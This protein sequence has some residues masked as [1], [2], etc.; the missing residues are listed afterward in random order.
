MLETVTSLK[1][2]ACP[3]K[4]Q[5]IPFVYSQNDLSSPHYVNMQSPTANSFSTETFSQTPKVFDGGSK[6][7][8]P[9]GLLA[10]LAVPCQNVSDYDYG[11]CYSYYANG[12]YNTCQFVDVGDIEDFM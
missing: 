6:K 4:M 12:C 11:L 3:K 2:T 1:N 9:N 8:I 7:I 5:N 10:K